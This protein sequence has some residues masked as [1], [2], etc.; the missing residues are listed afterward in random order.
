MFK[1]SAKSNASGV[2]TGLGVGVRKSG[3]EGFMNHAN[4]PPT[5]RDDL[6]VRRPP[7][8]RVVPKVTLLTPA[9]RVFGMLGSEGNL[10]DEKSPAAFWCFGGELPI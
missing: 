1:G 8:C 3:F 6:I 5:A 2:V 10:P 9:P 7:P 4:P